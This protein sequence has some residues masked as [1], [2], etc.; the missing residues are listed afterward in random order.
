MGS[1]VPAYQALHD[2][3]AKEYVPACLDKIGAS[4]LPNGK[5][6]YEHRVRYYTTLNLT[7]QQVHDTGLSEVK[8]IRTEMD[9]VIAK[10]GFKGSFADFV[11]FL[12]TD[13]RFYVDT[14]EQ[15]LKEVSLHLQEDGRPTADDV[16]DA[17]AH[18]LRCETDPRFHRSQ[19]DHRILQPAGRR[20]HARGYVLHEHVRSQGASA[21][22]TGS[23]VIPRSRSRSPLADRDHAGTP[24]RS[25]FSP[26]RGLHGV[27]R[28]LGLV[29]GAARTRERFLS[30]SLQRLRPFDVRDVA[31]DAPRRRYRHALLRLD[32]P[33]G[34]RLHGRQRR[35]V[36]AQHRLRSR[37]LHLVAGAGG[38]VQDR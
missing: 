4:Q 34:H 22:R 36:D 31:R 6:F 3:M 29:L 12:R 30:G 37:S 7:P 18:A 28:R 35:L 11:T 9:L 19:D 21:L 33:A 10:T 16:Q 25:Q 32:A 14:P 26:L 15:L 27:C 38:G 20:R 23:V 2:F 13:K 24:G 1:V 5:A 17:A 8:R